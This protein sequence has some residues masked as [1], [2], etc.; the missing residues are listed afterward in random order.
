MTEKLTEIRIHNKDIENVKSLAFSYF[1]DQALP[2]LVG[3]CILTHVAEQVKKQ[4]DLPD[5]IN[6]DLGGL[7]SPQDLLGK[8]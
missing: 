7:G 8:E 1:K 5:L 4:F 2:P 3:Y 6:I